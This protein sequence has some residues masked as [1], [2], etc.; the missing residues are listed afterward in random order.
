M[1]MK[2]KILAVPPSKILN[3]AASIYELERYFGSDS[4]GSLI[5]ALRQGAQADLFSFDITISAEYIDWAEAQRK[6]S[7]P[8]DPNL[9]MGA[10]LGY[11]MM[12]PYK[13]Y[14]M[15]E[16]IKN[17]K[18]LSENEVRRAITEL[19]NDIAERYLRFTIRDL[20]YKKVREVAKP[21][22]RHTNKDDEYDRLEYNGLVAKGARVT[23]LDEPIHLGF[24]HRQVVRAF[25]KRPDTFLTPDIF[26]EDPDIF[27]PNKDYADIRETLGKL[28]PAVHKR[29]QKAVGR[30]CIINEPN[31]GWRLKIE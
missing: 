15:S 7:F 12:T 14:D 18:P 23:Y 17:G 3:K 19:P 16:K 22:A 2:M 20:D 26:M 6:A 11:A 28:I 5:V 25:L 30:Q 4:V 27:S 10:D 31:E 24:Q 13:L 9:L 8:I 21:Q 29:L 1:N